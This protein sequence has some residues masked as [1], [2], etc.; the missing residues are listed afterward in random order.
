MLPDQRVPDG[1][2]MGWVL[3]CPIKNRVWFGLKKKKKKPKAGSG[4]GKTRPKPR[5]D[6]VTRG[7]HGSV[8]SVLEKLF[9][10]HLWGAVSPNA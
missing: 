9:A 3:P 4:F 10:P 2:R 8:R 6:S 7:V 1:T 5:P